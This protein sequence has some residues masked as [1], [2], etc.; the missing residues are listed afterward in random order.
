M[1]VSPF[2]RVLWIIQFQPVDVRPNTY[3]FK[4]TLIEDELLSHLSN[5]FKVMYTRT[6]EDAHLVMFYTGLKHTD[7]VGEAPL[8]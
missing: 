2:P 4:Q 3:I 5:G 1:R 6:N 8:Y 7:S